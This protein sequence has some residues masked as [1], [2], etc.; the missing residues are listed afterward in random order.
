MPSIHLSTFVEAAPERVFAAFTDFEHAEKNLSG[1]VR[2]EVLTDGPVGAGTRFRETRMMFKRETTETLEI[3][4]FEPGRSLTFSCDSHG[5][6][7]S[8]TFTFTP[9]AGGTRVD[10]HSQ[11]R[12]QTLGARL[13]TPM[14][15]L[16]AGSMKKMML[17]DMEELK[18]VAEREG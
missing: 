18:G 13:M 8:S 7:W 11:C 17:Q 9:E 16:F 3:T 10:L 4:G 6:L 14:C 15:F 5:S 1:V 2:L 12:A